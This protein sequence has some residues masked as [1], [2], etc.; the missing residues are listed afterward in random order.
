M[1]GMRNLKTIAN[2]FKQLIHYIYTA[3][4]YKQIRKSK[5]TNSFILL[6]C[7]KKN[8]G[9]ERSVIF[10]MFCENLSVKKLWLLGLKK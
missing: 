7:V 8:D 2:H 10:S 5:Y 4:L 1:I 6:R 3:N 9:N